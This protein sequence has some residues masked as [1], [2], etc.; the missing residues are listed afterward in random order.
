[1]PFVKIEMFEGRT[2]EKKSRLIKEVS[3]VVS[4]ILEI[5]LDAVTVILIDLPKIN[6]GIAGVPAGE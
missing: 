3:R 5:P 1:M 2:K 4:E 6:V